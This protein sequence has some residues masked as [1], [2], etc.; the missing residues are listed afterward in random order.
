[1]VVKSFSAPFTASEILAYTD[2]TPA[3]GGEYSY[4]VCAYNASAQLTSTLTWS[5]VVSRGG[6]YVF[7]THGTS[8]TGAL[9]GIVGADGICQTAAGLGGYGGTWQ[10]MLSAGGVGVKDRL[11]IDGPVYNLG[12]AQI[13]ADA[14]ALWSG[15]IATAIA[16]S[17]YRYPIS[18]T[19]AL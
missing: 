6:H 17:E 5:G 10:A 16:Y 7:A 2:A 1:A 19:L 9:G 8:N 3:A 15:V 12:G 11:T 14:T 4:R 13:A 18:G